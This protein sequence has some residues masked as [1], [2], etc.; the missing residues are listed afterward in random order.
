MC[1]DDEKFEQLTAM[2]SINVQFQQTWLEE[3]GL[4]DVSHNSKDPI[5]RSNRTTNTL[6]INKQFSKREQA[7]KNRKLIH[8]DD[9]Q[10]PT[11]IKDLETY[12]E[13]TQIDEA[14]MMLAFVV[15]FD[16]DT[17]DVYKKSINAQMTFYQ[18]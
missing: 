1:K 16:G 13:L 9:R 14:Q 4:F 6:S 12:S 8:I 11:G 10:I 5:E 17:H 18:R 2:S 7:I 3:D 15:I